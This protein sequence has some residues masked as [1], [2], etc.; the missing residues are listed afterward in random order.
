MILC[1]IC[2]VLPFYTA[3]RATRPQCRD[4][5]SRFP[6]ASF[7]CRN[8]NFQLPYLFPPSGSDILFLCSFC[9]V[10]IKQKAHVRDRVFLSIRVLQLKNSWTDFDKIWCYTSWRGSISERDISCRHVNKKWQYGGVPSLILSEMPIGLNFVT[11]ELIFGS[12]RLCEF[13][14]VSED[15]GLL[16]CDALLLSGCWRNHF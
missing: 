11:C 14:A 2:T 8:L 10:C 9:P 5:R 3:S 16:A 1:N 12:V 7:R 4:I 13:W 15:S 6:A